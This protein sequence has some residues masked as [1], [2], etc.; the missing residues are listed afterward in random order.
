MTS[1]WTT[2]PSVELHPVRNPAVMLMCAS[3]RVVVVLPLVPVTEATG[4]RGVTRRGPSPS[5]EAAVTPVGA[6]G[7]GIREG[8][9]GE[10]VAEHQPDRLAQRLGP[11]P[12]PPDEGAHDDVGLVRRPGAHAEP[13]GADVGRQGAGHAL[14]E[15]QE[16]L[17]ALLGPG[18]TGLAT[19]QAGIR[20]DAAQRRRPER[21][22]SPGSARVTLTAGRGK[23]RFGPSRTRTSRVVT[24]GRVCVAGVT[25]GSLLTR[26]A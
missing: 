26:G 6:V 18:G 9:A 25:A 13:A 7:H 1:P 22:G 11:G 20:R 14:D 10:Q 5:G 15:P 23:Y 3:S 2:T 19:A 8:A 12:V 4:M 21:R 17:L 16:H 24:P